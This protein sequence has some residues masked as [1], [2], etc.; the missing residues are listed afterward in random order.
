MYNNEDDDGDD[1][2]DMK[3][4]YEVKRSHDMYV[5]SPKD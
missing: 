4:Y 2:N 5:T 3:N 1:D